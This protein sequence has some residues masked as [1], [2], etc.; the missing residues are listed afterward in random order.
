MSHSAK[1]GLARH[2]DPL[3]AQKEVRWSSPATARVS[4][5]QTVVQVRTPRKLR[6][7]GRRFG[8]RRLCRRYRRRKSAL[9]ERPSKESSKQYSGQLSRACVELTKDWRHQTVISAPARGDDGG[10]RQEACPLILFGHPAIVLE[11][12]RRDHRPGARGGGL[13]AWPRRRALIGIDGHRRRG[14][15]APV[16]WRSPPGSVFIPMIRSPLRSSSTDTRYDLLQPA[17]R[18]SPNSTA[19]SIGQHDCQT[20]G[21]AIALRNRWRRPAAYAGAARGGAAEEHPDDRTGTG[22]RQDRDFH[23]AS[24]AWPQAPF[25][26][27]RGDEVHR[28]RLCSAATVEQIVRDL[29]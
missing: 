11:P 29:G 6:R 23:A 16:R 18:S 19:S 26:Q 27:G 13:C 2:D 9:F 3:P 28:D 20:R 14:G 17:A 1:T 12:R 4:M 24:R 21:V 25:C 10:R 22:V 5:G 8:D 7:L 15:G